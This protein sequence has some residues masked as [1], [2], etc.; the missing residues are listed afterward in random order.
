MKRRYDYYFINKKKGMK[1]ITFTLIAFLVAT[2]VFCQQQAAKTK[3]QE[4]SNAEK[5][6]D[7]SGT[8]IKKELFD[9]GSL[10]KCIE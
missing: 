6:S 4:I 5:F 3:E 1:R 7:R 9:V 10:N 8:W 2:S